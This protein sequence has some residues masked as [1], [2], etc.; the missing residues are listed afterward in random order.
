MTRLLLAFVAALL[1]TSGTQ[2]GIRVLFIGNSLTAVNDLPAMVRELGE[3]AGLRD[4]LSIHVIAKP[5]FSL[6]DHWNDGEAVRA[7]RSERWTH[8]V[9]QQ[10]PSS[11]MESRGP[12]REWSKRF[13]AEARTSGAKILLYGVWP[14]RERLKYQAD[15]TESYRLAAVDTGGEL[16]AVGEAWRLAWEKDAQLPL[17]GPDGFHPSPLGTYIAAM[18]FF[19]KLTGRSAS[20]LKPPRSVKADEATVKIVKAAAHAAGRGRP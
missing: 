17:Y 19:E 2:D 18:V 1:A 6:E 20:G 15:V 3:Q 13:A 16:V 14:P 9:L 8:I 11:L 5:N 12:L 7:V 10:G 4:Q